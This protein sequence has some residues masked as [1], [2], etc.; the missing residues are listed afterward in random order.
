MAIDPTQLLSGNSVQTDPDPLT[1]ESGLILTE[2]DD[3]SVEIEFL[4]DDGDDDE[5]SEALLGE[6]HYDN[7]VLFIDPEELTDIAHEVLEGYD[8]DEASRYGHIQ[9]LKDGLE[10]LGLDDDNVSTPFE[11]GCTVFHPLIMENAVKIQAKAEGELLPAAGPVRTQILGKS[12]EELESQAHRVKLHM[13]WQ[14]TEQITEYYG[15]TQKALLQAA[16]FGDCF[17]KK[18]YDFIKGRVCDSIIPIDRFVVNANVDSIENAERITEVQFISENEML[19]RQ[20]SGLYLDDV[21]LPE[22]YDFEESDL[23]SAINRLLGMEGTGEGY[24]ILEQQCYLT[25]EGHEHRSQV[26]LPYIVTMEKSTRTVLAIRRNWVEGQNPFVKRE[27]YAHYFFV[28]G[29][30]FYNLGYIHLLGN[31]QNT[32]TAIMRS[33]VDAGSFANMQGGFKSKALRV[34]DDEGAVAPGEWKDVEFY[35][36]DLSKGFYPFN[37]KEPSPTLFQL[38]E[39]LEI[40]GQKYADSAEQVVADAANY[41]PVGTTMALLDASNKFFST[42]FKRFHN[43]QKKE[44]KVIADLNFENLPEDPDAIT[45]NIPGDEIRIS[46]EDYSPVIDI[47][48]VSDPNISS[49]AYRMTMASQKL[50]SALQSPQLH[51]LRECYKQYYLAMGDENYEK[52][53]PPVEEPQRLEPLEDIQ[54]AVAGKPIRAFPDQDHDSHIAVKTGFMNDPTVMGNQAF[55][56]VLP[57]LQANIREHI[58]LR[59]AEQLQGA[60]EGM[61]L[62]A[63]EAVQQINEFNMYKAQNPMGQMDPKQLLAQAEQMK[64][65]NERLK[66]AQQEK[67]NEIDHVIDL[68]G[69]QVE[70]RKQDLQAKADKIKLSNDQNTTA[71][72][73][74]MALLKELLK[75]KEVKKAD[76]TQAKE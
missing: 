60:Q 34:L 57:I 58:V 9:D 4:D 66:I 19:R 75:A 22:P 21:D 5:L 15:N 69:L 27:Y 11:G 23:T 76:L 3:G 67:K 1:D 2:L 70:M 53:L 36:T 55:G 68:A 32:L 25:I 10:Q 65:E 12:S 39:W 44:L 61:G 47:L 13:N 8:E 14:T 35:G 52:Y 48:P 50:Q 16:L 56:P 64:Q 74:S 59:Y 49:A 18:Y 26:P 33:L 54:M 41:G 62:N 28:P 17:K 24:C 29:F 30:G 37:F 73:E 20:Y 42:V 38:L 45:F 43:A 40:R 46:R 63:Q 7:L 72:K 71:L 31:F 51:D 6:D